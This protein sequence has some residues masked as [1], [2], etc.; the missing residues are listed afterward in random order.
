MKDGVVGIGIDL[1]QHVPLVSVAVCPEAIRADNSVDTASLVRHW[2]PKVEL[3]GAFHPRLPSAV[4][5]LMPGEPL[6]VG[7]A[8]G[9]VSP[10]TAP[11][12]EDLCRHVAFEAL[13]QTCPSRWRRAA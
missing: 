3:R 6:L 1:T 2:P 13:M 5:P 9:M 10:V 8:A 4:L 12:G 7:D 11:S